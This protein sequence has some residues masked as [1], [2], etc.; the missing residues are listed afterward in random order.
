MVLARFHISR[1]LIFFFDVYSIPTLQIK[2]QAVLPSNNIRINNIHRYWSMIW[3]CTV[4]RIT[5]QNK[6][7]EMNSS[8]VQY[9]LIC[10][11]CH[12]QF[13][14]NKKHFIVCHM[15]IISI[16]KIVWWLQKWTS[17]FFIIEHLSFSIACHHHF[18]HAENFEKHVQGTNWFACQQIDTICTSLLTNWMMLIIIFDFNW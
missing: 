17:K 3:H 7:L 6:W 10:T 8:S 13:D 14:G 15:V 1:S 18:Y 9:S 16:R 12:W 4:V 11:I 5:K 2:T